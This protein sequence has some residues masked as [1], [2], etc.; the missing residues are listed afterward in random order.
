MNDLFWNCRG[1]EN[2]PTDRHLK[3]HIATLQPDLLFLSDS[4]LESPTATSA[5]GLALAWKINIS[6][7][8]IFSDY[9]FMHATISTQ[10]V[11]GVF[12][13]ICVHLSADFSKKQF[14]YSVLQQRIKNL[15]APVLII[16]D[17]NDTLF[18]HQK[19]GGNAKSILCCQPLTAFKNIILF[20][21]ALLAKPGWLLLKNPNS[22]LARVLN[23]KYY[24][25]SDFLHAEKGI[26]P[27]WDWQSLLHGREILE[28]GVRH[29]FGN[30]RN[31][32][33]TSVKWIPTNPP[34]AGP[35]ASISINGQEVTN[36]SSLLDET[37]Q[38]ERH[39]SMERLSSPIF[40]W[41]ESG[42]INFSNKAI[43]HSR[44]FSMALYKVSFRRGRLP[45]VKSLGSGT[46]TEASNFYLASPQLGIGSE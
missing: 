14:K 41:V 20:N 22:L 8:N 45:L 35:M 33:I 42:F 7:S 3:G 34:I 37:F 26:N 1:M 9:Y 19:L 15:L 13:L 4:Y 31:T 40:I 29:K 27:S 11:Q 18:P 38:M 44:L 25:H 17:F 2:F 12:V 23:G 21:Q 16:G 39:I 32:R 10:T 24:P 6:V 46:I 36:I 30:G 5:G 43:R 28:F